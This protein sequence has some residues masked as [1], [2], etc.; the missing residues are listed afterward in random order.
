V[1]IPR[2]SF[3]LQEDCSAVERPSQPQQ[4]S[5][6]R[7]RS[8]EKRSD[9]AATPWPSSKKYFQLPYR[10]KDG[11][12]AATGTQNSQRATLIGLIIIYQN[13][14]CQYIYS[15][16]LVK[17]LTINQQLSCFSNFF[18][19][20]G[21]LNLFFFLL[22]NLLLYLLFLLALFNLF[23]V[24]FELALGV[25]VQIFFLQFIH[26]L[27]HK[28]FIFLKFLFLVASSSQFTLDLL[29]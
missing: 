27:I 16:V 12:Y 10:R 17:S 11:V 28:L 6:V 14:I 1:R 29:L 25:K 3:S 21:C 23:L 2:D 15:A 19:L 9:D 26:D 4:I 5:H 13:I 20:W 24:F 8:N 22:L 18:L 7:L